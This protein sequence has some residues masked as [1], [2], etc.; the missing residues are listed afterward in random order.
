MGAEIRRVLIVDDHRSFADALSIAIEIEPDMTCVANEATGREALRAAM[1]ARPD[2]ALVDL[3]LP[4]GPGVAVI[5]ALRDLLPGLAVLAVTAYAD[6]ATVAAAAQAGVCG[7]LRKECRVAELVT[8]IRHAEDRA[9]SIDTATLAEMMRQVARPVAGSLP[10]L[11]GLRLTPR[12]LEVLD[13][14]S[15]ARDVQGIARRLGISIHT[16]RGYVK[17]L[18]AKF[19]VHTQLELVVRARELGVTTASPSSLDSDDAPMIAT[20]RVR[21]SVA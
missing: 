1:R 15:Q 10:I 14:L 18:L 9:M 21:T 5:T 7:F 20:G 2:V 4:D 16:A 19:E 3:H 12:E 17:S 13:L 6:A 11:D 8:A